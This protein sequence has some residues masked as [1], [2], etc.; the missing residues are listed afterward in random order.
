MDDFKELL[1]K[2]T[3]HI[4]NLPEVI[5]VNWLKCEWYIKK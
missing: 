3:P 4:H 1:W 2:I 5:Y